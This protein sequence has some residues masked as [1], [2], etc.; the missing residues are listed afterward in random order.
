M[1]LVSSAL[2]PSTLD[3]FLSG[4]GPRWRNR[5]QLPHSGRLRVGDDRLR[6]AAAE[7]AKRNQRFVRRSA[8]D[9]S[10]QAAPLPP[11]EPDDRVGFGRGQAATVRERKVAAHAGGPPRTFVA[12]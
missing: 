7:G 1:A 6:P 8:C 12:R 4:K 5:E 11:A 3:R 9:R 10:S 2:K